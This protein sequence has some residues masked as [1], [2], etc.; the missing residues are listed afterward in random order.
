MNVLIASNGSQILVC[1]Q[2][3]FMMADVMGQY[4]K[5]CSGIQRCMGWY[6]VYV[7]AFRK[8]LLATCRKLVPVGPIPFHT[9]YRRWTFHQ[10][11][12]QKAQTVLILLKA[13]N[14]TTM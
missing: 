4:R 12:C 6:T 10:R 8:N 14:T 13:H 5:L 3:K 9:T 2:H 11:R 1:E 7:P